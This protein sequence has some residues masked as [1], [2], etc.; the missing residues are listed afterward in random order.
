MGSMEHTLSSLSV[1]GSLRADGETWAELVNKEGYGLNGGLNGGL[2]GGSGGTILLFLHMLTLS[3]ASVLSSVGGHGGHYGGG[4]GGG[5]IHFDWSDIPTG[6]E[7]L[8]ISMVKGR[9][10]VR[11]VSLIFLLSF[12]WV[13]CDVCPFLTYSSV[14][15][16]L[17]MIQEKLYLE[18]A[19]FDA[20][21][22]HLP[23][24]SWA[25]GLLAMAIFFHFEFLLVLKPE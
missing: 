4:G 2:G 16:C 11:S 19:I 21:V 24:G 25:G 8:P 14:R 6:D 20:L 15:L 9:I 12:L 7:Y 22:V 23:L 10:S 1:Y 18:R 5:R 13:C 17:E 3:D